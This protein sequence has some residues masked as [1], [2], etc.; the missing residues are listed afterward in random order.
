M[1]IVVW[2]L[3]NKDIM[4]CYKDILKGFLTILQLI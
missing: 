4:N 1:Q 2:R 3:F